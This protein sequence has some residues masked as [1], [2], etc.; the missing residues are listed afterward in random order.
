MTDEPINPNT[1]DELTRS[2]S[3]GDADE[4]P[5]GSFPA[6][7]SRISDS[8]QPTT[9]AGYRVVGK[10]GEGGMDVV[11]RELLQVKEKLNQ[12]QRKAILR[13]RAGP[14]GSS[15]LVVDGKIS[16]FHDPESV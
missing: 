15:R 9:I 11:W 16:E 12:K 4:T 3:E 10:L 6:T 7:G 8:P 5:T 1:D 2:F 14:E 13:A